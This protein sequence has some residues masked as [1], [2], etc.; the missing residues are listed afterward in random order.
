VNENLIDTSNQV[1]LFLG[2]RAVY[3]RE[4][5]FVIDV[6]TAKVSRNIVE[7]CGEFGSPNI[8]SNFLTALLYQSLAAR[9]KTFAQG[10]IGQLSRRIK[11][12]QIRSRCV[13][14]KIGSRNGDLIGTRQ[15]VAESERFSPVLGGIHPYDR[16]ILRQAGHNLV[17]RLPL[18][19]PGIRYERKDTHVRNQGGS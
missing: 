12:W 19:M 17:A 5:V 8:K 7:G 18:P 4:S 6:I 15:Q 11:K 3:C 2:Y 16:K 1:L 10:V 13:N 9:F 14:Y